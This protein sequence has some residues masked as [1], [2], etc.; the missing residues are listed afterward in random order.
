[1]NINFF[2]LFPSYTAHKSDIENSLGNFLIGKELKK[3]H[4]L[5]NILHGEEWSLMH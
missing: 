4:E 5:Q 1:M 3:Q 2:N